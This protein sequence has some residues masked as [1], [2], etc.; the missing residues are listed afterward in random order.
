MD[1]HGDSGTSVATK[2]GGE[3]EEAGTKVD[4][5]EGYEP[6]ILESV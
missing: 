2:A 5:P 4:R 3:G 6:P 1:I